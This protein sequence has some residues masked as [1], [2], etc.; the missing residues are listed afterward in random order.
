M[1]QQAQQNQTRLNLHGGNNRVGKMLRVSE[2]ARMLDAHPNSVRRWA[3]IGLLPAQRI[4]L[5]GDRKFKLEDVE[6][7]LQSGDRG[8]HDGLVITN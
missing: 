1:T 2:V 8:A 7:F 5:R 4:G 3:D 6:A